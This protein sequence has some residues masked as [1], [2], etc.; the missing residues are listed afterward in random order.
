MRLAW[1][2]YRYTPETVDVVRKRVADLPDA[3][4]RWQ[5]WVPHSPIFFHKVELSSLEYAIAQNDRFERV[6]L[7]ASGSY[8]ALQYANYVAVHT[9]DGAV[10]V[11]KS[12]KPVVDAYYMKDI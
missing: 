11:I 10:F 4:P 6:V 2:E 5:Q 12:C 9:D 8:D 3:A 1:I 7:G